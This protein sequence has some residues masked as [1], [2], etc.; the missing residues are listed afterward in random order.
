M[1]LNISHSVSTCILLISGL[2][3]VLGLYNFGL[4]LICWC[5]AAHRLGA[6][7]CPCYTM[8]LCL[9]LWIY[10]YIYIHIISN[11]MSKRLSYWSL[12]NFSE[13][14][15]D[16]CCL[17]SP[18]NDSTF[19]PLVDLNLRPGIRN[20]S[21]L[22]TLFRWNWDFFFYDFL[23]IHTDLPVWNLMIRQKPTSAGM[24]VSWEAFRDLN[25]SP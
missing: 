4:L 25:F 19:S 12:L 11:Y 17:L 13:E 15:K 24:N 16:S 22:R 18:T 20:I 7:E 9:S 1:L 3:N 8:S 6:L 21:C 10:S 5:W 23:G 14:V 2:W